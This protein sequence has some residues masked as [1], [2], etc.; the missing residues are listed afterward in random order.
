MH[1]ELWGMVRSGY[2]VSFGEHTGGMGITTHASYSGE[3]KPL[4]RAN[5]MHNSLGEGQAALATCCLRTNLDG[6]QSFRS[7]S[8]QTP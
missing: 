1:R 3:S 4:F 8:N 6:G 2:S 7:T 5:D